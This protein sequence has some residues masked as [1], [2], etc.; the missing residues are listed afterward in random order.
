MRDSGSTTVRSGPVG[1][2][3]D[4]LP[5][6]TVKQLVQHRLSVIGLSYIGLILFVGV[7]APFIAPADP[8]AIDP[9]N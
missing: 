7:F 8:L 4:A 3:L 6:D 9:I 2:A 5:T 1:R